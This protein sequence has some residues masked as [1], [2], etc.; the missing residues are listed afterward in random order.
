MV[1]NIASFHEPVHGKGCFTSVQRHLSFINSGRFLQ[2]ET[3]KT[4][5][6]QKA[7]LSSSSVLGSDTLLHSLF[8][9]TAGLLLYREEIRS[10]LGDSFPL[11]LQHL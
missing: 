9:G 1:R 6:N 11:H 2:R 5:D 8:F 4:A 10:I 7:L 3:Q